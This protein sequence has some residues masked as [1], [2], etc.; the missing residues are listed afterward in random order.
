VM[1]VVAPP[2]WPGGCCWAV[3]QGRHNRG[4]LVRAQRNGV[5]DAPSYRRQ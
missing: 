5:S 2:R 3:L 1:Q 4:V